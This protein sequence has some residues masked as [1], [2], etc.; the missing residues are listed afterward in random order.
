MSQEQIDPSRPRQRTPGAAGLVRSRLLDTLAPL[1]DSP[2]A[3][4]V[5]PPGWGKT[6]LM[7]QHAHRFDGHVVWYRAA[8]SA[9]RPTDVLDHLS[10]SL[11]HS[12]GTGVR[13]TPGATTPESVLA[14]V[15]HFGSEVLLVVDDLHA[16]GGAGTD[17]I[18]ER[19]VLLGPPNLHVLV[20]SRKL[21]RFNL[22]RLERGRAPIL[23]ETVLPFRWWE[24]DR[25]FT[26][27]YDEPLHPEDVLAL[28]QL[29][30]GGAAGLHLLHLGTR[31]R[32]LAERRRALATDGARLV[33]GYL[34][35]EI[36][37]PLPP[38][39]RQFLTQVCVFDVLSAERCDELLGGTGSRRRLDE[40]V[41]RHA[42]T[43]LGYDGRTFHCGQLLRQ[44][45]RA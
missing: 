31:G 44:V 37:D 14:E 28:A 19:L 17:T 2:L 11:A 39:L 43:R 42:I 4:V 5:A 27:V 18:L 13:R 36:L 12:S 16:L 29:T 35:R 8:A 30:D 26:E 21:P 22:S 9:A 10:H 25:L 24:V 1:I 7:A 23:D 45:L 32:P 20:G 15:E 34:D 40:L 33:G 38:E 6:T 41:Q 3:L